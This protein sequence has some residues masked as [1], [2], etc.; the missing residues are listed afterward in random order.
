MVDN[1]SQYP[2][3]DYRFWQLGPQ[4]RQE[5]DDHRRWAEQTLRGLDPATRQGVFQTES[6]YNSGEAALGHVAADHAHGV[7]GMSGRQAA[8]QMA[9][10]TDPSAPDPGDPFRKYA[11]L[12]KPGHPREIGPGTTWWQSQRYDVYRSGQRSM[13]EDV[14]KLNQPELR[15]LLSDIGTGGPG[16]RALLDADMRLR[17]ELGGFDDRGAGGSVASVWVDGRQDALARWRDDYPAGDRA[18]SA[19]LDGQL[20]PG[21]GSVPGS[22]ARTAPTAS[23]AAAHR[24]PA[25]G[26]DRDPRGR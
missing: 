23:N 20:A 24:Y 14:A 25:A 16:S 4:L 17:E 6:I 13:L 3:H 10:R 22:A 11:D 12:P 21:S 8:I 9:M 7:G 5:F 19:A 15:Q 18:A 2:V 1:T 26:T